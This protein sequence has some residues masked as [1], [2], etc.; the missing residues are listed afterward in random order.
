MVKQSPK[1]VRGDCFAAHQSG[2]LKCVWR[3]AKTGKSVNNF[4]AFEIIQVSLIQPSEINR[5][6]LT[7]PGLLHSDTVN[8]LYIATRSMISIS[9]RS[10]ECICNKKEKVEVMDCP[11]L[12]CKDATYYN[13]YRFLKHFKSIRI[14]ANPYRMP[15]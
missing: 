10:P 3:L 8:D 12:L 6:Q 11:I 15:N 4:L 13:T 1:L 5:H 2:S 7:Y 14:S 9:Q